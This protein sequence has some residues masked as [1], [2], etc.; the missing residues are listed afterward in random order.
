MTVRYLLAASAMALAL[1]TA[2]VQAELLSGDTGPVEEPTLIYIGMDSFNFEFGWSVN[3]FDRAYLYGSGNEIAVA[4]GVSTVEQIGDASLLSFTT[5][6]VGP[7]CD[8][9]CASNGVGDFIVLR[10]DGAYGAFR[11]DDIVYDGFDPTVGTLSGTWWIQ[12]D[13][14]SQFAPAVPEP[15]SW[16]MLLGGIALIGAAVR[17]RVS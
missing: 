5:L 10:R 16:A 9:T 1:T 12:L 6:F 8:A 7:L 11:I 2:P 15:A 17:R 4:P 3:T 13:G 14:T